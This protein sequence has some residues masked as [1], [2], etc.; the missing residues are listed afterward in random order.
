MKT[1]M[2]ISILILVLA[3]LIIIGGC[4]PTPEIKEERGGINQE[5][6][7][8]AV[9]DGDVAEVKRLIEAGAKE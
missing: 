2:L 9:K 1:R 3:V 6:F 5:T 8:Q 4:A 7:F